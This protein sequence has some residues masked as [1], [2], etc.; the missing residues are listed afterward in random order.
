MECR[1]RDESGSRLFNT[2]L[3]HTSART[4]PRGR[5]GH[6]TM[7]TRFRVFGETNMSTR[8]QTGLPGAASTTTFTPPPV[9]LRW[10]YRPLRH[11]TCSQCR[12]TNC[13]ARS[14]HV[15][16]GGRLHSTCQPHRPLQ[17][18]HAWPTHASSRRLRCVERPKAFFSW[19]AGLRKKSCSRVS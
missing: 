16:L 14:R 5:N 19:A 13:R 10:R 8:R 11:L 15:Y 18:L 3:V 17:N 9:A 2:P 1:E 4:A 6:P 7:T 12:A